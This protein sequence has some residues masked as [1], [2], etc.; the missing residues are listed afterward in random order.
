M[1]SGKHEND[2]LQIN[3][4]VYAFCKAFAMLTK[5]FPVPELFVLS[6]A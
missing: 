4:S 2:P 3:D 5:G 6:L 1:A